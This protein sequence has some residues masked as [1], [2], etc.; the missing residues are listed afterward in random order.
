MRER[1]LVVEAAFAQVAA[2]KGTVTMKQHKITEIVDPAKHDKM[3]FLFI[4]LTAGF[5]M[6]AFI[7]L[8]IGGYYLARALMM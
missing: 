5:A 2:S 3:A 4:V 8:G 1:L 7:G 6:V